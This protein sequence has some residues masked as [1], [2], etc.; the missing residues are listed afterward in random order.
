MARPEV[1]YSGD[2]VLV[3]GSGARVVDKPW[4]ARVINCGCENGVHRDCLYEVEPVFPMPGEMNSH[5]YGFQLR[6]AGPLDA[7][8]DAGD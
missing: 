7:L 2:M 3:V 1:F 4:V 5:W 6:Q 8:A